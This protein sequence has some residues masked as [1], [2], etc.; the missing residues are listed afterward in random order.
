M[1]EVI[2]VNG[3]II[4]LDHLPDEEKKKSLSYEIVEL[5]EAFGPMRKQLVLNYFS[6]KYVTIVLECMASMLRLKKI[7]EYE[8][9]VTVDPRFFD[10][11]NYTAP[12]VNGQENTF[13]K[14][15][16]FNA[17]L[18]HLEMKQKA[19]AIFL[20]FRHEVGSERWFLNENYR[21]P[22]LLLSFIAREKLFFVLRIEDYDSLYVYDLNAD[23]KEVRNRL[24]IVLDDGEKLAIAK[25]KVK[26]V[27]AYVTVD[28]NFSVT[29]KKADP[30]T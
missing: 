7:Y 23:P 11:N 20:F 2:G 9:Y 13:E 15:K 30:V 14:L 19:F 29:L 12:K 25:N 22:W 24:C 28:D 1:Y 18:R 17:F 26:G 3:N 16:N 27:S 8:E 4:R 10:E 6:E 21:K 5:L